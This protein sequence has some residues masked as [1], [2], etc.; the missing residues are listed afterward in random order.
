VLGARVLGGPDA[1]LNGHPTPA[2]PR[3]LFPSPLLLASYL[4]LSEHF[5][6]HFQQIIFPVLPRF[7]FFFRGVQM[8]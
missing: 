6:D 4:S 5:H 1:V 7:A 8:A 3:L 2:A